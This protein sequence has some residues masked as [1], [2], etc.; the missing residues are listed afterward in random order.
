M[1]PGEDGSDDGAAGEADR[2]DPAAGTERTPDATDPDAGAAGGDAASGAVEERPP[3]GSG[4]D[5][6]DG[7]A[8]RGPVGTFLNSE[9]PVV[10]TVREVLSSVGLVVLIG[11]V[12]FAISGV[13]PPLVAVESGSMEPHMH[14]GDLVFVMEGGRF[15]PGG[16]ADAAVVTYREGRDSGYRSF[17]D[18]GNVV[19]YETAGPG[20]TPIIHRAMFYVEEDE[21]W[22][23]MANESHLG[24]VTDCQQIST[25]PANR[26]GY[27]TKGDANG[28]YDQA[29]GRSEVVPPERVRG[30]AKVRVPFLGCIRLELAGNSCF[31]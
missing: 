14:K 10:V 6:Q 5:G 29:V 25:C 30:I 7:T 18:Y 22:V 8:D 2:T 12:L 13:W 9:D 27:V 23:A 28:A 11:L 3:E 26:S 20:E 4:A 21:D 15:S 31:S 16:G 17:G 1:P 19:V 24:G